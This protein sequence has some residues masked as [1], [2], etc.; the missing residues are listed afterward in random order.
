MKLKYCEYLQ[1]HHMFIPLGKY[2]GICSW[3]LH[4]CPNALQFVSLFLIG[5]YYL[6]SFLAL[7]KLLK[8]LCFNFVKAQTHDLLIMWHFLF[9]WGFFTSEICVITVRSAD[10]WGI[11]NDPQKRN[12]KKVILL[13]GKHILLNLYWK[14]VV[15]VETWDPE[16]IQDPFQFISTVPVIS[17]DSYPMLHCSV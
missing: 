13:P 4:S 7:L 3:I 12:F 16:H 9:V 1:K 8:M 15:F 11:G 14:G 10:T 6:S 2:S 17:L 5:V